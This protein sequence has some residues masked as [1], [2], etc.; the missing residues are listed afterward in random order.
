MQN[1]LWG[2]YINYWAQVIPSIGGHVHVKVLCNKGAIG[3][4][5]YKGSIHV[6]LYTYSTHWW[7]DLEQFSWQQSP[8][9]HML[10]LPYT[11]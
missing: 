11:V 1:D 3:N 4:M 5:H 9:D 6:F 7:S 10:M 2:L 8:L